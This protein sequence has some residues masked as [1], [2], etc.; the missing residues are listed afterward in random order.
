MTVFMNG[1]QKSV[2]RPVLINGMDPD[3]YIR[4]NADPI[5]LHKEE[6]WE[7]ISEPYENEVVSVEDENEADPVE[8]D[9]IPF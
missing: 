6:M 3:E 1:R 8:G 5:W 2:R 7:Y 4:R 9:S